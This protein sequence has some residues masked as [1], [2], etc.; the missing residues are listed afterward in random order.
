MS[1]K[2][3]DR[4]KVLHEAG[5]GRITQRQAAGQLGLGERQVRRLLRKVRAA[6]D[7]GVIHGLRGRASNWRIEPGNRSAR[8][9]N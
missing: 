2:E 6:G 5:K 4:L 9:R 8:S 1:Q 3:R 7:R